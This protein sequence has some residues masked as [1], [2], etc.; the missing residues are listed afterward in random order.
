M[1]I[2]FFIRTLYLCTSSWIWSLIHKV[3][4]N[5]YF[6]NYDKKI[7]FNVLVIQLGQIGDFVLSTPLLIALKDYY[8]EN[9]NLSILGDSINE[10]LFKNNQC[11][12]DV[13]IYNSKKYTKTSSLL[14]KKF[15]IKSLDQKS[16]DYVIWL[17]GDAKTFIWILKRRI[18]MKSITKEPNPLRLNWLPLVT[19][20]S[21]KK[22]NKHF[23][24]SLDKIDNNVNP[25][26]F[27]HK[28]VL[29][30]D[31][32]NDTNIRKDIFVHVSSGNVLR[33]WPEEKFTKLLKLLLN[34]D[35]KI[36]ISIIGSK[37]DN[38]V[39]MNILSSDELFSY[40]DRISNLCG[41]IGLSELENLFT[42]GELFIGFDSGPMHIASLSGIPIV[43]LMG[44]QSPQLF[45]PWGNQ[46]KKVIYKDYYCSPCWQRSCLHTNSGP[47]ACI[48]DIQPE[49]VFNEARTLMGRM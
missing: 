41:K 19:K 28:S 49:E 31:I 39:A 45:G 44:P 1:K 35:K 15:P 48:L 3:Y 26:L 46:E 40:S 20:R 29:N 42:T 27:E 33:R 24:E 7:N 23:I 22:D 25:S 2:I 17:R 10:N 9:I 36:F 16:I 12:D 6:I 30:Y 38:Q 13:F 43:A 5:K 21:M 8:G 18:P 4:E 47:G 11:L 37:S 32:V 14:H 34:L